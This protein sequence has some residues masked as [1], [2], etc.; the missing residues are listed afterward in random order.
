MYCYSHN[1]SFSFRVSTEALPQKLGDQDV[2]L[3]MIAAPITPGKT[4]CLKF[5]LRVFMFVCLFFFKGDLALVHGNYPSKINLPQVGGNEGVASVVAV[6]NGVKNV[7][8]NDTVVIAN[9][10]LGKKK[11]K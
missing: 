10:G 6:G 1:F 7:K 2:L 9:P 11:N 8:S 3:K 5:F 4:I